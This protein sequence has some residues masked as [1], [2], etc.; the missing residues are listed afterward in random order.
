MLIASFYLIT[1]LFLLYKALLYPERIALIATPREVVAFALSLAVALI[2]GA[3]LLLLYN[4]ARYLAVFHLILAFIS[5]RLGG[6]ELINPSTLIEIVL[7]SYLLLHPA[8]KRA[9]SD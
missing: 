1:S 6:Y 2:V 9:F 5:F 8:C 3:G 7:I 4:W